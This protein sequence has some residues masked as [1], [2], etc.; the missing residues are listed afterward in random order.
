MPIGVYERKLKP[1]SERLWA[2]VDK[3]D[4][5]W[6]WMGTRNGV[7]YG[8]ISAGKAGEQPRLVHR[9]AYE[10][11]VGPIPKGMQLDHLCRIRHCVHPEHLEIVTNRENNLRVPHIQE[12]RART[13]CIHGHLWATNEAR[14]G[15][16]R[17][18]RSCR[19]DQRKRRERLNGVSDWTRNPS[20]LRR[21]KSA[22]KKTDIGKEGG[23]T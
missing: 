21:L 18:C 2:K 23:T 15:T 5:C 13:H 11:L 12:A 17:A 7:G 14:V 6:L 19:A 8:L 1:I 20:R 16:R 9:V 3:T 22:S 10:L 4:T